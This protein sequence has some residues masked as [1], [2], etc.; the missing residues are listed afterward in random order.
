MY[1]PCAPALGAR[2]YQYPSGFGDYRS[3]DADSVEDESLVAEEARYLRYVCSGDYVSCFA[4]LDR[5][6]RW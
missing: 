5:W 1:I 4:L 3:T 6:V 2:E